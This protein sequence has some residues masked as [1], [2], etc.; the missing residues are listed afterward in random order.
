MSTG[1]VKGGVARAIHHIDDT[2]VRF[3]KLIPQGMTV[4][5]T[6]NTRQ[7]ALHCQEA[8]YRACICLWLATLQLG[9]D[10]SPI[11][12]LCWHILV[13]NTCLCA[14]Y[15]LIMVINYNHYRE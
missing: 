14:Q 6:M 11:D 10:M 12:L 15:T 2:V 7:Q 8:M 4:Q 3:Y 13:V 1:L 5:T 9:V